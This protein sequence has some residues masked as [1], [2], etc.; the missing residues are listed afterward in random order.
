MEWKNGS[1][2]HGAKMDWDAESLSFNGI[3]RHSMK[4]C[5]TVVVVVTCV[6]SRSEI[7]PIFIV[8]G[9][10]FSHGC[11]WQTNPYSRILVD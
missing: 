3:P 7:D 1:M 8:N 2:D 11:D 9:N 4:V 5:M 10:F 6:G